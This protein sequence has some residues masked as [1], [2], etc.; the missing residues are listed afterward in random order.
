LAVWPVLIVVG[1]VIYPAAWAIVALGISMRLAPIHGRHV[2]GIRRWQQR[3]LPVLL[4][5]TLVLAGTVFGG[6]RLK[7]WREAATL[8][9][10]AGSPNV[11]L[12]MLDT[13]RADHLSLYGY[14]RSTSPFLDRLAERGVRFEG[15]RATAS[16]T[17]PS[18]ASV[19]T[20]LL[21]H[22]LN[23]N[24]VTPLVGSFQTLA[25]Y[26]GSRGYA[27][28]GFVANTA[29]CS[30]DTGLDRGF[31]HYE[32]YVLEQLMPLRTEWLVDNF[33]MVISDLGLF[34]ARKFDVGPFRS[35][36]ESW[37]RNLFA[38]ERRK[39]AEM[40]NGE[41]TEWL[42]QRR[43][44]TRPF[45]A[46]LNYYDAHAPY[47]LPGEAKYRFGLKPTTPVDFAFLVDY[48]VNVNKLKIKPVLRELARDSYD[49]CIAY[50]D[51]RLG[52]LLEDLQ[53]R[54]VLDHTWLVI[55]ADHG[56]GWGEHDLF[57]HGE[58]LYREEI[59]V[60]L[61]IVPPR[62][63]P[64]RRVVK[65]TVSLRSLPATI[66]D[67]LD[68]NE[69]SPFPGRS[70]ATL[71][72]EEGK[73]RGTS[74]DEVISE[75]ASPNMFN[76]NQGR[77]PARRGPLTSLAEGDY[78]YIRNEGDG[79]EELFNDRDDP[80]EHRNLIRNKAV[81]PILDRFRRRLD[82]RHVLV[83]EAQPPPTLMRSRP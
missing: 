73:P 16:W 59:H 52:E 44:S 45:F 65:E 4:I 57:D 72:R 79:T 15:A 13:V 27:T 49:N 56:E 76:P 11:L 42:A 69:G 21:P 5:M 53:R 25:G 41:F 31:T 6:D 51:Q 39:N 80:N 68:L 55:A 28:A 1:P 82:L 46:F 24:P 8:R 12:V 81:A 43:E 2:D 50:L 40:I 30:Y 58:S 36:Q 78:V 48:W 3:S 64:L 37:V 34:V 7:L 14:E 83:A 32:D 18:H 70:L 47:V 62:S 29:Y 75:L 38:V 54:G 74:I 77:S 63:Q 66:V 9:P 67:L 10:R 61:L 19:F 33:L 20:G 71:W 22:E 17:L 23:V 26:L 60:P 35:S